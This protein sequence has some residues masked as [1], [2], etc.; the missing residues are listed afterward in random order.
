VHVLLAQSFDRHAQ[1]MLTPGARFAVHSRFERALNLVGPDGRLV[2]LVGPRGGNGP[3]TLVLAGLPLNLAAA[4]P[5]QADAVAG[6]GWLRIGESLTVRLDAARLW[7]PPGPPRPASS[8][9]ILLAVRRAL[10]LARVEAP[11]DGLAGLLSR[12]EMLAAGRAPIELAEPGGLA[13]S[14]LAG[15]ALAELAPAW[16]AGD[17]VIA[18][19]AARALV[20]LGPGQ[21]P[22]GDDLLAGLLVAWWRLDAPAAEALGQ[23]VLRAAEG[24]TTDLGLH[25]LRYAA[26]GELDER[27]EVA[28]AALL[29]GDPDADVAIRDL[30]RYGH[31]SGLDTLVGL[32]CG[33][34]LGVQATIAP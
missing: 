6:E 13:I 19:R 16:R 14:A 15:R 25:R 17:Q 28:L 32:A 24:R 18:E 30:L 4:V 34:L 9:E 23:A 5:A 33:L 26:Q 12:V 7:R 8:E 31:S 1:A 27:S 11:A 22:S 3:A 10:A 20:G 29:S 2:G 21:T